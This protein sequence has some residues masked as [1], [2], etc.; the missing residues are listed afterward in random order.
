MAAVCDTQAAGSMGRTGS[1]ER[2]TTA[3]NNNHWQ[4]TSSWKCNKDIEE[5]VMEV[6]SS[7]RRRRKRRRFSADWQLHA[8]LSTFKSTKSINNFVKQKQ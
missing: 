4:N 8:G 1:P 7:W 2:T 5:V 6:H 3:T